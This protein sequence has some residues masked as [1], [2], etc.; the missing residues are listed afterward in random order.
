MERLSMRHVRFSLSVPQS[1]PALSLASLVA[2][3]HAMDSETT[4]AGRHQ[5]SLVVVTPKHVGTLDDSRQV[6]QL[7]RLGLAFWVLKMPGILWPPFQ[8]DEQGSEG[9][10][11]TQ[12]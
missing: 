8:H 5:V 1:K 7:R 3:H 2:A 12:L 10:R 6:G 11:H 4:Y 9:E